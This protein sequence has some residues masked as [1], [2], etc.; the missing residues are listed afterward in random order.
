[1]QMKMN[2]HLNETQRHISTFWQIR[3]TNSPF[4]HMVIHIPFNNPFDYEVCLFI[5]AVF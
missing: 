2:F 1:M 3:C 5:D 4:S